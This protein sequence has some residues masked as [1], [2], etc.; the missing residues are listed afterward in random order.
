MEAKVN[1]STQIL[2]LNT[3]ATQ[4][5]VAAT[6]YPFSS[7]AKTSSRQLVKHTTKGKSNDVIRVVS[8][9]SS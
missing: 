9:T 1:F 6:A 8:I 3:N 5:L 4:T 2:I 7:Y